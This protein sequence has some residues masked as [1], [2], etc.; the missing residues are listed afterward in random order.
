M[1]KEKLAKNQF[2]NEIEFLLEEIRT[3]QECQEFW[4][5]AIISYIEDGYLNKNAL[6]WKNPFVNRYSC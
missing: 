5:S 4:N 1:N 6:R 2:I 3:R